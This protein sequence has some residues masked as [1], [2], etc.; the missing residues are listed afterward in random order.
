MKALLKLMGIFLFAS[1]S[2]HTDIQAAYGAPTFNAKYVYAVNL[3]TGDVILNKNADAQVPIASITKLMTALVI[4]DSKLDL[5]EVLTISKE[6]IEATKGGRRS[7]GLFVGAEYTREELLLIALMSSS[8]RAAAALARTHPAGYDGFI[9]L[10]ND[11]AR[12]LNMWNTH[13][14]DPT[15]LYNTNQ[16]SPEDLVKLLQV[17]RNRPMIA[18]FSTEVFYSKE[19]QIERKIKVRLKNKKTKH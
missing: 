15:G 8:N 18:R 10:M 1:L 5:S 12:E 9:Q 2:F 14:V 6:D 4:T 11:K 7:L 13:F 19:H 17:I 3:D 16:S